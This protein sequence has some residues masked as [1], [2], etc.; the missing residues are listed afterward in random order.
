MWQSLE[1]WIALVPGE[2]FDKSSDAAIA[3]EFGLPY[4]SIQVAATKTRFNYFVHKIF[5]SD[6]E[7]YPKGLV[8]V[9]L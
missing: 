3:I 5:A 8:E 6:R 2:N 1:M 4:L 7:G 9:L